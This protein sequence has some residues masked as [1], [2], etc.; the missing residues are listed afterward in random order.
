MQ[1]IMESLFDILYLFF[2]IATGLTLLRRGGSRLTVLL[3]AASLVLGCGDAFHLIPRVMDYWLEGDFTALLGIGKLITSVTMTVFYLLLE[4]ARRERYGMQGEKGVLTAFW[5]LAA[6]RI[7]L[8]L[9]PQNAWTSADAPVSWGIYRNLPFTVMGALSLITW[10]R[11]ARADRPLRLMWLAILLSFLFYFPVVLWAQAVPII[12][13][14]MLPKTY[15]YIWMLC[16]F[17]S[18]C[19]AQ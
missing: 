4:Y 14:L 8:C 12:G 2:A 11:S 6:L 3:G 17:R 5:V 9:F 15:M 18:A 7:A 10:L 16:V 13:M 19:R 1:A